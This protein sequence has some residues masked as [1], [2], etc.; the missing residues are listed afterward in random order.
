[1]PNQRIDE[2]LAINQ[3]QKRYYEI[4]SG[5][6][7][8]EI[9]SGATNLWRR[10]RSRVLGAFHGSSL[11]GS[12]FDLHNRWIGDVRGKKVLELGV[13]SGSPFT[14]MLASQAGEYVA[15]DLSSTRIDSLRAKLPNRDN[16]RL[17][18]VDFLSPEFEEDGFDF[19]YADA[20]VHHFR[21]I[22]AFLEVLERKLA[23][24]G[25]VITFDPVNVWWGARLVRAA[26]RPFQTD[27]DWEYPFSE[28]SLRAI[29]NR[30]DVLGCQGVM[31]RSKWAA[32]LGVV[33][34]RLAAA[35]AKDWHAQDLAKM[36]TPRALR[37][38][39]QGSYH[40]RKRNAK[41]AQLPAS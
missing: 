24:N 38:C 29:E 30:F 34:P 25:R 14:Q 2:M 7:T 31:G 1:M 40:L 19:I 17:Y 13:G 12:I 11:E 15:L 27:A 18:V 9:N 32:L 6:Q 37:S 39:L 26:F 41:E 4:A 33:S 16:V 28:Q 3:D 5:G 35:K 23:A 22:E 8:H 10:L 36:T 21:H 20:V